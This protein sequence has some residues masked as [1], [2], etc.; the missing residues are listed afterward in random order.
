MWE[1]RQEGQSDRAIFDDAPQ[2][3]PTKDYFPDFWLVICAEIVIVYNMG[4]SLL[5]SPIWFPYLFRSVQ[6]QIDVLSTAKRP[7]RSKC[8][9]SQ[10][11]YN[12][13][14]DYLL[15]WSPFFREGSLTLR[16]LSSNC[17]DHGGATFSSFVYL[18]HPTSTISS[19]ASGD[20]TFCTICI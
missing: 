3:H 8:I 20:G 9:E 17:C 16:T 2:M 4:C 14:R 7:L 12:P 19:Q 18:N 6:N 10:S 15:Q 13:L 1:F 11:N 5:Y